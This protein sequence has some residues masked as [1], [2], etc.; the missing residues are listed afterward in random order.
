M[1]KIVESVHLMV[2]EPPLA[3]ESHLAHSEKIFNK[4]DRNG[5]GY[6]TFDEFYES[7]VNVR[8]LL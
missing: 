8:N 4:F 1:A 7:C 6:V 5:D 2:V 3:D